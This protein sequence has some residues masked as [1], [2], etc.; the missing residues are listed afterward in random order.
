MALAHNR[1]GL[2]AHPVLYL[3]SCWHTEASQA[4]KHL[5]YQP[6]SERENWGEGGGDYAKGR[7]PLPCSLSAPAPQQAAG[8][9]P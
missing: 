8:K 6:E 9:L 4:T 1:E 5:G 2:L 3:D 7:S